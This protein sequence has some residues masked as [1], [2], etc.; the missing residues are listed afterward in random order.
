MKIIL[1][2]IGNSRIKWALKSDYEYSLQNPIVH[3]K[4]NIAEKDLWKFSA[5][6]STEDKVCKVII[7]SVL[8]EPANRY[9]KKQFE[10]LFPIKDV[11]FVRSIASGFGI[12]NGYQQPERLGVDRF[13]AMV[14][15]RAITKQALVVVDIGTAITIDLLSATGEHKGGLISAGLG[16]LRNS[17]G[18]STANLP[19]ISDSNCSFPATETESAIAG[20]TIL[21]L[22]GLVNHIYSMQNNDYK[23]ILTGGDAETVSPYINAAHQIIPDL[24][25]KGL[26][27]IADEILK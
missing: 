15:A 18:R 23:L 21:T 6:E 25:F 1:I 5:V 7:S 9:L 27:V 11:F 8:D 12:K 2:D 3:S 10:L 4:G 26:N 14:G 19:L 20:G 13:V 22:A 17:L 24:I 16:L